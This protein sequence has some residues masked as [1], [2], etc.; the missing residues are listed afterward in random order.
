M[1]EQFNDIVLDDDADPTA[2][3]RALQPAEVR[4]RSLLME[5]VRSGYARMRRDLL[6]EN[7]F[8][9]LLEDLAERR[10]SKSGYGTT[11]RQEG[12]HLIVIGE[13]GAG[14]TTAVRRLLQKHA[15]QNAYEQNAP[16]CKIVTVTAPSPCNLAELGRETLKSLGY[17]TIRKRV[18]GPEIWRRVRER[19]RDLQILIIHFDEMQHVVQTVNDVEI[20]KVRN[21]IKGLLVDD[22]HPVGLVISGTDKLPDAGDG[23]NCRRSAART[24][25]RSRSS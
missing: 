14:K 4:R 24:P 12:N 17:P 18:D 23:W 7:A 20:Q 1:A 16:G 11:N 8:E 2:P 21:I 10:D 22:K 9:E 25:R 15:L 19:I 6:L 5:G 13:S 3:I